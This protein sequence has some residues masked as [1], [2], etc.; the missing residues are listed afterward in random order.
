[1]GTGAND[2]VGKHD[3]DGG[4]SPAQVILFPCMTHSGHIHCRPPR[5]KHKPTRT[6]VETQGEWEMY[7]ARLLSLRAK[8][9][10]LK[11]SREV[12]KRLNADV[13]EYTGV[14]YK[15]FDDLLDGIFCAYLAYYFWY[16]RHEHCWVVG[17][18][19][20]GYVTLPGCRLH[21]CLLAAGSSNG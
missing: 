15:A 5:Y 16:W 19:E 12:K 13:E 11:F 21:S 6:W 3:T 9:P 20:T 18:M 8:E 14:R 2:S 4:G 1:M 17:N 10:A 7:R